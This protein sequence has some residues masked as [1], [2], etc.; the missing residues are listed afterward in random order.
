[1]K[2]RATYAV[3]TGSLLLG[4]AALCSCQGRTAEN[5]TPNGDTVEVVI[6]TPADST[7]VPSMPENTE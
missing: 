7:P 2:I 4:A 1:M 6:E 3:A 5:M